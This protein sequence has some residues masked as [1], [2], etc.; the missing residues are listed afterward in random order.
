MHAVINSYKPL[1]SGYEGVLVVIIDRLFIVFFRQVL[2]FLSHI[3]DYSTILKRLAAAII[4]TEL[5]SLSA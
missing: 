3:D 2:L 1:N 4:A 5:M